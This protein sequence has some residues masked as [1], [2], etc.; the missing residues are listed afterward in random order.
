MIFRAVRKLDS[1]S[2]IMKVLASEYPTAT[3][4]ARLTREH[5]LLAS[6]DLPGVVRV[7]ELTR[8]N[9]RPALVMEDFGA[10]SL[11]DVAREHPFSTEDVL[12]TAVE[13]ADI[14]GQIHRRGIVHRDV[15][16]QNLVKNPQT[17][18]LKIIDFDLASL[19]ADENGKIRAH[20]QL[21]GTL[22]YMAPE[23][24]GR[25]NRA[26]DSRADLYSLGATLYELFT[27]SPPFALSDPMELVHAH[28]A[29]RPPALQ[30][31]LPDLPRV[32]G[33]IVQKLL[34]KA[35]E[36][37]YQTALGLKADLQR[38][39]EDLRRTGTVADFPLGE[40]DVPDTLQLPHALYGREAEVK[41]LHD[42]FARTVA[43]GV[44]LV[45]LSGQA[46][47]GKS[48]LVKELRGPVAQA[49]G[50]FCS[51][52]F[53]QLQRDVPYSAFIAAFS[54]LVRQALAESEEDLA[55]IR[56]SIVEAVGAS[57]AVLTALI[58]EAALLL[59]D[60]LPL[61]A[62][63]PADAIVRFNFVLRAFVGAFATAEHPLV[64]L[65]DDLQWADTP[66]LKLLQ[67]LLSDAPT[68]NL[69]FVG[70]HREEE[71]LAGHA[72]AQTIASLRDAGALVETVRVGLLDRPTVDRIVRDTLRCGPA[73]TEQLGALVFE[74][75]EGNPFFVGQLLKAM[76]ED[77]LL[78]F[79]AAARGW[80]WD[81]ADMRRRY[82]KGDVVELMVTKI[83]RLSARAQ[84]LLILAACTGNPVDVE[85]VRLVSGCTA[86]EVESALVEATQHE[87]LI[88]R[89]VPGAVREDNAGV[90]VIY[91]LV[92][93]RVQ[94]AAYSLLPE[95]QRPSLHLKIGRCLLAKTGD[96]AASELLFEIVHHLGLG[97]GLLTSPEEQVRAVELHLAA[98][99]RAIASA[100]YEP[101]YRFAA[102]AVR[103]V[104]DDLWRR[105][106][107]T[108]F[109]LHVEA[110]TAAYLAN[111]LAQAEEIRQIALRHAPSNVDRVRVLETWMRVCAARSDMV[112]AYQI[113]I[114]ALALFGL[115][116]P[117]ITEVNDMT[118]MQSVMKARA[119]VGDR[120][121]ADLAALPEITAPEDIAVM[122]L[123]EQLVVPA[124]VLN[125]RVVAVAC[126][127]AVAFC[128]Q[129]GTT[130]FAASAY[131]NYAM[132]NS[133]F[134]EFEGAAAYVRL[135]HQIA[136]RYNRPARRAQVTLAEQNSYG[137]WTRL[138][139]D[140]VPALRGAVQ[141]AI[142]GGNLQFAGFTHAL[143]IGALIYAGTR[144]DTVIEEIVAGCNFT[145][146]VGEE[147]ARKY[148]LCNLR[149]CARLSGVD[150]PKI[151]GP[152][153]TRED[154]IAAMETAKDGAGIFL[155]HTT[156]LIY[157]YLLGDMDSAA[158]A[159]ESAQP[160]KDTSRYSHIAIVFFVFYRALLLCARCRSL[161]AEEH[162][163][164][165]AQLGGDLGELR[166][167]AALGPDNLLHKLRLVEA[168]EAALRGDIPRAMAAYDEAVAGAVRGGFVH[169]EALALERAADFYASLGRMRLSATYLAV[170]RQ[171][172]LQWGA[173]VK[174]AQIEE[175]HPP[176]RS[177]R[178]SSS[179]GQTGTASSSS[180]TGQSAALDLTTVMKVARAVSSEIELEKLLEK[181]L[182]ILTE[183]AGAER[184]TLL[185]VHD[186]R[187]RV[188]A[189]LD[190]G[191]RV[192]H[193]GGPP[194]GA[195]LPVS[196]LSF[197]ARSR[198]SVVLNDA[199]TEGLFSRDPYIL[200][201]RPR[202]VLCAPLLN[203][204]KL[205]A[206]AYLE[207][208]LTSG[209]FTADR[210]EML[211]M[212]SSQAALSIH[213]A[214]LYGSLREY[215]HTLEQKVEERTRELREKNDALVSAMDS[216]RAAQSQLIT[217]EKLAS[218]GALTAGIAHELRNPLNFVN[219]FAQLAT[220]VSR[221]LGVLLAPVRTDL[222]E[223]TAEDLDYQLEALADS[224][225]KIESHG[226]RATQ[227]IDS[228]L[229]HARDSSME[230]QPT[231]LNAL[232]SD[233]VRL[234][235]Q[236]GRKDG[237]PPLPLKM[238]LR[239]SPEIHMVD[240]APSEMSRVFLNVVQNA[241]Y[242]MAQ[243]RRQAG[244]TYTPQLTIWSIPLG[245]LVE[246]RVRDN[247]MGM[248]AEVAAH[249]FEPFFTTKPAGEGSG[250][251][252]SLSHD[253]VV[254]GHGGEMSVATENGQ[255]T[256]IAI[257]IPRSSQKE[258]P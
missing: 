93:D 146:R 194:D 129:R 57:A 22:R 169:E 184:A 245:D 80:Q 90:R 42:A 210:V 177:H 205:V 108:L 4:I 202:S 141:N 124:W 239:L 33:E 118:V 116:V 73:Q 91:E 109:S 131:A 226:R 46:G 111:E 112:G 34:A 1:R 185:L 9:Q 115:E 64:I 113:G 40:H 182:Q 252:L 86:D 70:A 54:E 77:G 138:V 163:P 149:M 88:A 220:S 222:P 213:N 254:Q 195:T 61:P 99:V 14:L 81:I 151:P 256:E 47:V 208:N 207:N 168:E 228:M 31:A 235:Y 238:D 162:A 193:N 190:A 82:F 121:P 200:S 76:S 258:G 36:D 89:E 191:G 100:A 134:G 221:E 135:A 26:V 229:L 83:R 223:A 68:T 143:L 150:S 214:G 96:P 78:R 180:E 216:L 38:C 51:G 206:V 148:M 16:P 2:V 120:S 53:D 209:A 140:S 244:D 39:L 199:A 72:L 160:H 103:I 255:Y 246:V 18:L 15:N 164:L 178:A 3:E 175:K 28:I 5:D 98:V 106:P 237:N 12:A 85:L 94:Q 87:L 197:V 105:A 231:D 21:Q 69:L 165:L 217:Q 172:Y 247:G 147:S 236:G 198:E 50:R 97:I 24:T 224:V 171:G 167:W 123:L 128:A 43:G 114:E 173:A 17:G 20:S 227:I 176:P 130:E 55:A 136:E 139:R 196:I 71:V 203:Q 67:A 7:H 59:G 219:N 189:Q 102:A 66:S 215:S 161:P 174:V 19:L 30:E 65:L 179:I 95:A 13:I 225:T 233:A 159:A 145:A 29:R 104:S 257:R 154:L 133:A 58:P 101:A 75:T 10:R 192:S 204:G 32:V 117:P 60:S 110:I 249:I 181:L 142:D 248:S 41:Q 234:A 122:R 132:L 201:A 243:K 155:F 158:A 11:G 23:Q 144:L 153:Y 186:G 253:I 62:L 127:E 137:H 230:R 84:E 44:S 152:S 6:L 74:R 242:A 56:A 35:P 45:L 63:S 48:A 126:S 241:V 8:H 183:N 188:E 232:I 170:A 27:G 119:A 212:I 107:E 251:G 79:N 92:H 211:R 52:K 157:S 49:K 25:M 166:A 156:E 187:L 37:R 250:L 125:V 240:L 218:L